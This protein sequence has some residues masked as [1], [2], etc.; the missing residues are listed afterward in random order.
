MEYEFMAKQT[1]PL[2]GWRLLA[3][4]DFSVADHLATK[5]APIRG[6]MQKDI[7]ELFN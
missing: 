1:N 7:P 5:M 2:E 4:R 3:D 6:F